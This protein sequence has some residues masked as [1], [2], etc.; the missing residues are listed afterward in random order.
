MGQAKNKVNFNQKLEEL[1]QNG[2]IANIALGLKKMM[3]ATSADYGLDCHTH[4]LFGQRMLIEAG[5]TDAQVNVG[6]ASWRVGNGDGDVI[7]HVKDVKSY[8]SLPNALAFHAWISAGHY[9]ID[10]STYQIADKAAALDA[11]DGGKTD[12]AWAPEYLVVKKDTISTERDVAKFTKGLY[13]YER[14]LVIE[15]KVRSGERPL[16]EEDLETLRTIIRNPNVFVA[17]PN[18][19]E[20][21]FGMANKF[22]P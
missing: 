19:L 3:Q 16:K 2:T 20:P 17:G 22:Q 21:G 6:F 18:F 8:P 7:S 13:Y 12:V 10:F 11:M 5:I 15:A 1:I 14:D 9:L 4:A